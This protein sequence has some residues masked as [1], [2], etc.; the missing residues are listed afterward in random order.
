MIKFQLVSDTSGR[1]DV[2]SIPIGWRATSE[3]YDGAEDA[4]DGRDLWGKTLDDLMYEIK[5]YD[6]ES[7]NDKT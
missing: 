2:T 1:W 5:E 4:L 3:D 7:E 6:L